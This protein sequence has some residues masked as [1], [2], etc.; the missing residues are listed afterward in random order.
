MKVRLYAE[1]ELSDKALLDA[2]GAQLPNLTAAHEI[3]SGVC[4][5]FESIAK[6][7]PGVAQAKFIFIP[8]LLR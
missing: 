8:E 3:E 2:F 6:H 1:I 4:R 7:I 5:S